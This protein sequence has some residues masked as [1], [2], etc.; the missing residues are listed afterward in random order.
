MGWSFVAMQHRLL[1]TGLP[2]KARAMRKRPAGPP[3]DAARLR[4]AALAHLARFGTTEAGLFRVLARR[5]E[6]WARAAEAEGAEREALREASATALA[7]AREIAAGLAQAGTVDD[8]AFATAR[9][10]RLGRAGRSRR[11]IAAHLAAKGVGAET[12]AAT[13]PQ[14]DDAELAAALAA[15][16]RR[17]AGPFA[18]EPPAPEQRQRALAALARGGF[19]QRIARRAHDMDPEEADTLLLAARRDA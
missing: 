19:S 4:E 2:V 3:P 15:L 13:L 5:V 9:A 8:A 12:A 11:A 17:R 10:R 18:A 14:N 16:R 6:R 7:A 1:R